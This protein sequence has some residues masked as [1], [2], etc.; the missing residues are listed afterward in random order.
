MRRPF[1][2]VAILAALA[3]H[4]AAHG[5]GEALASDAAV[6]PL[7]ACVRSALAD[8][9][10]VAEARYAKNHPRTV[11]AKLSNPP[12]PQVG[13]MAL[14]V[15]PMRGTPR[16]FVVEY[17]LWT[18]TLMKP[19]VPNLAKLNAPAVETTG[20]QLLSEVR[21]RCV[22]TAAGAPAGSVSTFGEKISGRCSVGI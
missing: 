8:S 1:A 4:P 14:V 20:A 9:P 16:Q 6:E 19:G 22:P 11:W 10:N 5:A 2:S 12:D 15:A 7:V 13:A 18:G 21:N 3:C 17:S